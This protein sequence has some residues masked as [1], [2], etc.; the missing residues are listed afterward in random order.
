VSP[1]RRRVVR[2]LA[3][4]HGGDD[5]CGHELV[6]DQGHRDALPPEQGRQSPHDPHMVFKL[7]TYALVLLIKNG[8]SV[9]RPGI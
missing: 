2:S 5:L 6:A 3:L 1:C 8:L 7:P 4:L 9:S